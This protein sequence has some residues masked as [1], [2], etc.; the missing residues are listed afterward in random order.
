MAPGPRA[1]AGV[2][3]VLSVALALVLVLPSALG[4]P[5]QI[6]GHTTCTAGPVL[7]QAWL[8]TP[9][10]V[11]DSP[12]T[13]NNTTNW[14]TASGWAPFETPALY[15]VSGGAAGGVFSLDDWVL[16][17]MHSTWHWGAGASASCPG[18]AA[19]D[20][21]RTPGGPPSLAENY[22][23]LLAPGA[24]SDVGVPHQ[25]NGSLPAGATYPSVYFFANYTDGF[26]NLSFSSITYANEIIG[27]GE[28]ETTSFSSEGATLFVVVPF[29]GDHGQPLPVA[30]YLTGVVSASYQLNGPWYGCIQWA[31]P[32]S[33]FGT[34]LAFGPPPPNNGFQCVYP[35]A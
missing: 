20:L 29:V 8:W 18:T 19:I 2:L 14:V 15:T 22:T 4:S 7:A 32:P 13:Y 31:S 10:S 21:S 5:N 17:Q 12:P 25:F 23:Q 27:S 34:G 11:V 30:G 28:Y 26:A 6:L 16:T 33:P 9:V 1:S 35:K 24:S 3:A